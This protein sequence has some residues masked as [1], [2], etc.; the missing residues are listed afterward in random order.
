MNKFYRLSNQRARANNLDDYVSLFPNST[1]T[2]DVGRPN[3]LGVTSSA[4]TLSTQCINGIYEYSNAGDQLNINQSYAGN[5]K[6]ASFLKTKPSKSYNPLTYGKLFQP[7]DLPNLF[8]WF[9]GEDLLNEFISPS[10]PV[11]RWVNRVTTQNDFVQAGAT[12][13][14]PTFTMGWNDMPCLSFDGTDDRMTCQFNTIANQ[15]YTFYLYYRWTESPTNTPAAR[16]ILDNSSNSNS[17]SFRGEV[18]NVSYPS[19][20]RIYPPGG[21]A[22]NRVPRGIN[23]PPYLHF[24]SHKNGGGIHDIYG[25]YPYNAVSYCPPSSTNISATAN[26]T[27]GAQLTSNHFRGEMYEIVVFQQTHSLGYEI[28]LMKYYFTQKYKIDTFW[29]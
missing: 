5:Q 6:T 4:L 1:W 29:T 8:W 20:I 18:N 2:R 14:R 22:E 3:L 12:N 23:Y 11:D 7:S 16:Y 19:A 10:T 26:F 28:E 13:L 17:P 25:A 9:C 21:N 24:F 27:L 15:D